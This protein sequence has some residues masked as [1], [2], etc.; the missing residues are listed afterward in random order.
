MKA[1]FFADTRDLFK[2]DLVQL[3]MEG[4]PVLRHFHFVP[5][6]TRDDGKEGKYHDLRNARAGHLNRDLCEFLEKCHA[7]K[8]R[9]VSRIKVYF[10]GRGIATDIIDTPFTHRGRGG[11]FRDLME[12]IRPSSLVLL[13]PDNGLGVRHPD[14]KHLLFPELSGILAAIDDGSLVMVFQYYPRVDHRIYRAER[15]DEISRE[16]GTRPIW[17]TDN[18]IIFYLL[19]NSGPVKMRAAD[20]LGEYASRYPGLTTGS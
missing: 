4:I 17:I 2:Y 9:D 20:L 16:T 19:A 18:Q 12:G 10:G 13:D 1:R 11:Y 6:L 3:L 15:G 14:E 7:G 5:M 8:V